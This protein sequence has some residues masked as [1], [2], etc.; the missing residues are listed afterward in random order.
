[1]LY[2]LS[3]ASDELLA[4]K[5]EPFDFN[6]PPTDPVKL[7]YDLAE[8]MTHNNGLGLA[9]NQL[10]L[11]YRAFVMSSNPVIVVFNPRIV[12]SS[13]EEIKIKEGCLTYP[14]LILNI[15]RPKA[16]RARY[17]QPNGEVVTKDFAGLS[18]R[19]FQ[20]ETDHLNGI[21]FTKYAS[22]LE[23]SIAKRKANKTLRKQYYYV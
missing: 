20:H 5:L 6:N 18:A 15:S 3:P 10:G 14:G 23:L 1:M 13:T 16:I 19:I 22:R 17:T 4:T 12:D 9:A 8:T 2:D 21:V 11:P 7:A